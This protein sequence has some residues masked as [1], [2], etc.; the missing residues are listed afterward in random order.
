MF[1]L[2]RDENL[3]TSRVNWHSDTQAVFPWGAEN[4]HEELSY[5]AADE[6]PDVSSFRGEAETK[7]ELKGRVVIFESNVELRSDAKNLYYHYQRELLKNGRLIRT[8]TWNDTI[9]RDHQ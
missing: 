4:Y 8:K 6:Q 7:I 2:E 1:Q 5:A 3:H 9:P